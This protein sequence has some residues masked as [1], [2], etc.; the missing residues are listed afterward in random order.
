MDIAK[1][2]K[3]LF[4][5]FL[6]TY[7]YFRLTLSRFYN[8]HGLMRSS[9]LAY[10]LLFAFIPAIASLSLFVTKIYELNKVSFMPL[11]VT[12]IHE[13]YL[14][15]LNIFLNKTEINK[16]IFRFLP[17]STQEINTYITVF[18]NN[19]MTIGKIG[20]ILLL[21]TVIALVA[22]LE[23]IFNNTWEIKKGRPL[24]RK[25]GMF[26]FIIF[27]FTTTFSLSIKI[28]NLKVLQEY[29][30]IKIPGKLISFFLLAISFSVLYK[31][32]PNT[33]V[34]N[35]SALLG[36]VL[37]AILYEF[38]RI[39]FKILVIQSFTYSKIYGSL[40]LIPIF[41]ISLFM[42][43]VIIT[44]GVEMSYVSQNFKRLYMKYLREKI[45]ESLGKTQQ[46]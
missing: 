39:G 25:I 19:A 28:G 17:Y 22:T 2:R 6:I 4:K 29:F 45:T 5:P 15:K 21:I 3:K 8:K 31:L 1:I 38:S 44:L 18:V 42:L 20:T 26:I 36:G 37:A 46:R 30:F 35:R 9:S 10:S 14:Q 7:L 32:I 23:N 40:S 16:V 27:L 33:K 24:Y 34:K 12:K 11:F 41:V 43:S 13:L